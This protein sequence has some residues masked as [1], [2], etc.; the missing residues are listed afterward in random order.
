M[1][2]RAFADPK[3]EI[4]LELRGRRDQRRRVRSSRI[5]LRDTVTGE[6]RE[7]PVTGLFIAIGHDPRSELL[8][9]QVDLDDERLRPGRAPVDAHQPHR[10]SSPAGD[11]VD[12][13]YRRR[14]PRPAPA[15]PPPSTPSATSRLDH[16]AS[17]AGPTPTAAADRRDTAAEPDRRGAVDRRNACRSVLHWSGTKPP[18]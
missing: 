5:T 4:R 1:Q 6:T 3:I 14:S 11:L 16:A 18:S 13:H 7:L 2:E 17:T 12:H 10:A 15:A 8:K 9:G